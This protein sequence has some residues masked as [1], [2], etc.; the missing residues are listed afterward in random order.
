MVACG[1]FGIWL[2]ALD[3]AGFLVTCCSVVDFVIVYGCCDLCLLELFSGMCYCDCGLYLPFS[4][5][6]FGGFRYSW[7]V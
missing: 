4:V 1:W 2:L 6:S 5:S 3:G 7:L